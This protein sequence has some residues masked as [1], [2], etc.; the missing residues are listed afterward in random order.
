MNFV[1]KDGTTKVYIPVHPG[2][3]QSEFEKSFISFSALVEFTRSLF[4]NVRK[5]IL[6]IFSEREGL[7]TCFGLR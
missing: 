2:V 3:F 7:W 1:D 6:T 5:L 4:C